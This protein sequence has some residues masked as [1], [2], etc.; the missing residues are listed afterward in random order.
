M[1]LSEKEISKLLRMCQLD[2]ETIYRAQLEENFGG[3]EYFKRGFLLGCNELT[4]CMISVLLQYDVSVKLET[5]YAEA[6]EE[7]EEE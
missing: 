3:D 7:I 1:K 4:K 6:N 2:I 5:C